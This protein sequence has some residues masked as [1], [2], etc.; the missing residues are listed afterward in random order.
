V[1]DRIVRFLEQGNDV[2]ILRDELRSFG[3]TSQVGRVLAKL[4][5][6]KRLVRVSVGAY[7]KTR[8]NSFTG[9]LTAAAPL[10]TIAN[11]LFANCASRCR[12]GALLVTT[13]AA[14]RRRFR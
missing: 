8:V 1:Q 10:E 11:L 14:A 6:E 3:S 7:A 12:Q 4:V 2:V 9:E 13:T 5:D